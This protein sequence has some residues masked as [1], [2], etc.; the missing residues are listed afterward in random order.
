[1]SPSQ[2]LLPAEWSPAA[3]PAQQFLFQLP[4]SSA[5]SRPFSTSPSVP[6]RK[7][8]GSLFSSFHTLPPTPISF[9]LP[10]VPFSPHCHQDSIH[11]MSRPPSPALLQSLRTFP[12]STILPP[13]QCLPAHSS[14]MFAVGV[15]T[16]PMYFP[17]L[18]PLVS[19]PR[20]PILA[21]YRSGF[22]HDWELSSRHHLPPLPAIRGPSQRTLP[23]AFPSWRGTPRDGLDSVGLAWATP[24]SS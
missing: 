15:P 5:S 21:L 9:L 8:P 12:C 7:I 6:V 13:A 4:F 18:C 1:M 20:K 10:E 3:P 11:K 23:S 19:Q 24:R 17:C 22:C 2:Y 14:L 16:P